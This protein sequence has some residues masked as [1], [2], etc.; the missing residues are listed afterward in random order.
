LRQAGIRIS[1][2]KQPQQTRS[3]Q[4]VE[5]VL[6]AA[7]QVL[8]REGA[9]RFT[10]ARVA[11][12]AG[13]SVGSL[14]QYFP[15]KESILFRLQLDEWQATIAAVLDILDAP[16]QT[17]FERL[18]VAIAAFLRSECEEAPIRTA[19]ADAAPLF[20]DVPEAVSYRRAAFRRFLAFWREALPRINPKQRLQ[21]I[22]LVMMTVEAVG[23]RVSEDR[24]PIAEVEA[25]AKALGDMVCAYLGQLRETRA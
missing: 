15:N 13:V 19:L 14:Y 8:S 20:R 16:D 23:N 17:P 6:E 1:S 22:D 11:E 4:L 7:I 25:C 18:R 2:R 9:R 10:T 24:R 12:A 5:D 21:A 3:T